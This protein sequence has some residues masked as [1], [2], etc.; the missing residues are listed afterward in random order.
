MVVKDM[1][2]SKASTEKHN[3][4]TNATPAGGGQLKE[5]KLSAEDA[6]FLEHMSS[7]LKGQWI[8]HGGESC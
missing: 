6:F 7:V 1:Y 5:E 2:A 4:N 8:S 3:Q